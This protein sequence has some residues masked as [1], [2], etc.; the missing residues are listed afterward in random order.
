[1]RILMVNAL[2]AGHVNPG[3]EYMDSEYRSNHRKSVMEGFFGA[4]LGLVISA[5]V[6]WII[7]FLC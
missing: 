4:G 2:C 6:G 5:V 1:M 7:S 3:T